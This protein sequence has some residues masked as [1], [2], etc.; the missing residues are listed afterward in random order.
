MALLA[1]SPDRGDVNGLAGVIADLDARQEGKS[2]WV[3]RV[4]HQNYG[5]TRRGEAENGEGEQR[6]EELPLHRHCAV[7]RLR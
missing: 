4:D 2:H 5:H 7:E 6:P 1:D 3:Y